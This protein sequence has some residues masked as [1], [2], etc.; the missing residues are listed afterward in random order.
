MSGIGTI[1]SSALY[2]NR[3]EF[4]RSPDGVVR[5]EHLPT[6][7]RCIE[8]WTSVH[9]EAVDVEDVALALTARSLL[10]VF[11]AARHRLQNSRRSKGII[12]HRTAFA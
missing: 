1:A 4:P 5:L 12:P 11:E 3:P 7:D 6:V 8:Y 10:E 9:E 2:T